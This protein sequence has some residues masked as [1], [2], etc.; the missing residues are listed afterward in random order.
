MTDHRSTALK[1]AAAVAFCLLSVPSFGQMSPQKT[2]K[3][4]KVVPGLEVS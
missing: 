3:A 2:V 1:W 4:L